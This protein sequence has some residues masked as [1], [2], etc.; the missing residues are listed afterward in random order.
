MHPDVR[1]ERSG[2]RRAGIHPAHHGLV[3]VVVNG[4][5]VVEGGVGV[6][7]NTRPPRSG[8]HACDGRQ[9]GISARDGPS[10]AHLIHRSVAPDG[11]GDSEVEDSDVLDTLLDDISVLECFHDLDLEHIGQCEG[12]Q[13]SEEPESWDSLQRGEN[14]GWFDIEDGIGTAT[15]ANRVQGS[16]DEGNRAGDVNQHDVSSVPATRRAQGITDVELIDVVEGLAEEEEQ[17]NPIISTADG[18]SKQ[19]RNVVENIEDAA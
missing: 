6:D 8:E 9:L 3:R 13:V 5:D 11:R 17:S 18:V 14:V 10:D 19:D 7:S 2:A 1:V 16:R 15:D 12:L 4:G